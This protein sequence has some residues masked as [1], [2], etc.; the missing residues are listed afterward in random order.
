MGFLD[1]LLRGAQD[2]A[3]RAYDQLNPLDGG[4]NWNQRTAKPAPQQ[5][6]KKKTQLSPQAQ[7]RITQNEQALQ[8]SRAD[9][10]NPLHLI[11]D[12]G[13]VGK[14]IVDMGVGTITG[15][16]NRVADFGDAGANVIREFSGQNVAQDQERKQHLA[17]DEKALATLASLYQKTNSPAKRKEIEATY[18]RVVANS[19]KVQSSYGQQ[20]QEALSALD[21]RKT[22][23]NAAESALDVATAGKGKLLLEGIKSTAAPVTKE[24]LKL[25]AKNAAVTGLQGAGLGASYAGVNTARDA[26]A[27]LAD[28][29]KNMATGA[30]VGA[31]VGVAAQAGLPVL[32]KG[33]EKTAQG[34]VK[35][36]GAAQKQ[37]GIAARKQ[38]EGFMKLAAADKVLTTVEPH[39]I[40]APIKKLDG[41]IVS[42]HKAKI[43]EGNIEP[44]I[45]MKNADNTLRIVDGEHRFA[46]YKELGVSHVPTKIITPGELK[47]MKQGGYIGKGETK[48]P[49]YKPSKRIKQ[50]ENDFANGIIDGNR[51]EAIRTADANNMALPKQVQP[52]RNLD[53]SQYIKEQTNAQKAASKTGLGL[54]DK[55]TDFKEK[56]I[57][58]L[59]PIEDRLNKAIKN[60]TTID[61]KDHITYQLDRSRRAE[62]IMNAYVKDNGLDKVIQNVKNTNEFDQYL[63]ARHA[64]ELDEGITTGRDAAKDAALVKQLDGQ[65]GAAAKELYKYNQKLLDSSVEY[66]LISKETAAQLKKQYP[67]YVPFNRIFNED[68]LASISGGAG[69]GN[70]SLSQQNVVKKIKGS[71]RAIASP[72]NS[73]I[74]KTRVVVEQGERNKAAQMLASY[75]DLEGNPFN[76]KELSPSETIGTKDTIA[77]LDNGKKRVFETDKD[78]AEAAKNMTR[79]EIG[80]WGRIAAVPARVLR[81]GATTLN[82]GFAGANVVKDIVGA[83]INSRHAFRI[84]DPEAVGK[85]L[86]AALHHNGK[87][88]QE[89]MREGVSGTSFDMY[90]NPLKSNVGE[91]RSQKNL[92]TRA[93]YN[94]THPGQWVRTLENTIG[95][96]EDF[97]RALQY[98]SNKKGYKA[99]GKSAKDATILAAD[100]A[101]SNST[102]FFRHGSI[103]KDLN[104]AVP[105][106]NAGVQGA[107]MQVRRVKERPVQTIA[108][109]GFVIAAP[110]AMIAM[111]NYGDEKKREVM[112]NIPD[113]EKEG[114]I[115][116]VG[117]NATYNAKTNKW[118][119]VTKIPVPP[120]H[121]GVHM[122][123]QD[124]VRSAFTGEA[125]KAQ[126]N[127]G[128]IVEDLTTI[129][130]G[131]PGA[132]ASR[133]IPQA[134]KL[135]AEPMTNT[136]FYTK[137]KI[138]PDSQKNLPAPDQYNDYTSGTAKVLGKTFNASPRMIDN[139]IRTGL[140]GAGQNVVNVTDNL[141]ASMGMIKKDE[142]QGK[143]VIDSVT[144]RFSGANAVSPADKAENLL[145]KYKKQVTAT[146]AYKNASQ[147]DKGRMLNRLETDVKAVEWGKAPA[148][149]GQEKDKLTSKQQTLAT[150][151]FKADT[152]TDLSK[153][154][155]GTEVSPNLAKNYKQTLDEFDKLD[156]TQR[157]KK[158][159]AEPDAEFRYEAAKYENKKAAGTLTQAE[160]IKAEDKL[161]KLQAGSK[162]SKETR[163]LYSLSKKQLTALIDGGKLTEKQAGDILAYGDALKGIDGYNKFKDKNGN[164]AIRPKGK[165][166]G[167]GRKK[168]TGKGKAGGK[169]QLP[170]DNNTSTIA[171]VSNLSRKVANTKVAKRSIPSGGGVRAPGIKSY[172]KIAKTNV[173]MTRKA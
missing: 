85:A 163:D 126:K 115:I 82:V 78:I 84:A 150:D 144:G 41:G 26:N 145:E 101:R 147:Y 157:D 167:G 169:K 142:V 128:R 31:G 161:A 135:I 165:G 29:A 69:K 100:Q 97:G 33:A 34:A 61:P 87:Y 16:G 25:L 30:A 91:I 129:N 83:A 106:W 7:Q 37:V 138:V 62:G 88:Y 160:T 51:L 63:I 132:T 76:L 110:S 166:S 11:G 113:Y 171:L 151:G 164:V 75:K 6:P 14:G 133:L 104:L 39:Y 74:D 168:G 95:R 116:I 22:L 127:I 122:S 28:Y 15:L 117:D 40:Q 44:I 32:A 45:V 103:G 50:A 66:G 158:L 96:S 136:N 2:T 107:R 55:A 120:Q 57:D 80:M 118:E 20:E 53:A 109:I 65:Y 131:D 77:Y 12:A 155:S 112:E 141:L 137:N 68:E 86:S 52:A 172:K 64:K 13:T 111:N 72:L 70:A 9:I 24:A 8:R 56:F 18:S 67:E 43:L 47:M 156:T 10:Y 4:K 71:K 143:S 123:I 134:L 35:V 90:R 162:F 94:V 149:D 93:A 81:G 105:Y 102:N 21:P 49:E 108:K 42:Q 98:Y 54:K 36:A 5:T 170:S 89:L 154:S 139:S 73:I 27:T 19:D 46:A 1:E 125:F 152:Y 60:G 153:K 48:Q 92:G 140:G 23:T 99:D 124:A 79:E 148:K 119:G 3:S 146:D 159:Y 173:S 17:D 114:N 38:E 58:D 59:A 130:A 121:M